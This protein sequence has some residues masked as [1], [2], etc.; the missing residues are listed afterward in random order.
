MTL[1]L[2]FCLPPPRAAGIASY[3][4]DRSCATADHEEIIEI[5]PAVGRDKLIVNPEEVL[6]HAF[7]G[8]ALQHVAD[9][10][11]KLPRELISTLMREAGARVR[12][13]FVEVDDVGQRLE[14][15]PADARISRERFEPLPRALCGGMQAILSEVDPTVSSRKST[16]ARRRP[17]ARPLDGRHRGSEPPRRMTDQQ[18]LVVCRNRHAFGNQGRPGIDPLIHAWAPAMQML[19][20]E[21]PEIHQMEDEITLPDK[22]SHGVDDGGPCDR[23]HDRSA[24]KG[25]QAEQTIDDDAEPGEEASITKG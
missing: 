1:P 13:T 9:A 14:L 24:G 4:L 22:A 3:G 11:L 2:P 8:I 16:G 7:V 20:A 18:H 6:L 17:A 23:R 12:V 5:A 15:S 19:A 21:G 10:N 25:R